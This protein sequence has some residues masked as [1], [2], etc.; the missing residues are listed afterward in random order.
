MTRHGLHHTSFDLFVAQDKDPK[1][2]CPYRTGNGS[3]RMRANFIWHGMTHAMC[4]L[5]SPPLELRVQ[6][7]SLSG[8]ST[9]PLGA[10]CQA[11]LY[12]LNPSSYFQHPPAAQL[13]IEPDQLRSHSF[14]FWIWFLISKILHHV[15]P[16]IGRRPCPRQ[17]QGP[18]SPDTSDYECASSSKS[19]G[20]V[21]KQHLDS[22][23][24]DIPSC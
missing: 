12:P 10:A 11:I 16:Q 20:S 8:M 17:R 15:G 9:K 19:I 14:S 22:F 6:G 1:F 21:R 7:T 23:I 3:K 13:E 2:Y 5:G 18:C 4:V 24:V